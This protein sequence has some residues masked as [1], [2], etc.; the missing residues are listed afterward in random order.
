MDLLN[1]NQYE[2]PKTTKGKKIVITLLIVSVLLTI[3]IIALMIYIRGN[4]K[5]GN[6]FVY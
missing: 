1:Q 3:V 6:Y 2:N 5:N 4:Q